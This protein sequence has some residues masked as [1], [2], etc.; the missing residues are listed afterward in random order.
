MS[1]NDVDELSALMA[2]LM[3]SGGD[4][5]ILAKLNKEY[6]D[7]EKVGYGNNMN[8]EPDQDDKQVIL[9]HGDNTIKSPTSIQWKLGGYQID[10]GLRGSYCGLGIGRKRFVKPE[11]GIF[12]ICSFV[13]HLSHNKHYKNKVT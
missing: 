8:D 2:A 6:D 12:I 10:W 3:V 4:N 7:D 5:K 1:G 9:V 13:K 11:T